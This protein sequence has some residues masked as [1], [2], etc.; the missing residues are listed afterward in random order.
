MSINASK[1]CAAKSA[2]KIDTFFELHN[3]F[4]TLFADFY[5]NTPSRAAKKMRSAGRTKRMDESPRV[6]A[7]ACG[8]SPPN[9]TS[10]RRVTSV[11]VS[12]WSPFMSADPLTPPS[13]SSAS[14]MLV[15]SL[16]ATKPSAL[17][18]PLGWSA[19]PLR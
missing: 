2:A 17:A 14:I 10:I 6:S 15:T 19:E 11:M 9:S 4:T 12:M 13:I 8:Y 16:M 3:T 18:S 7:R 5:P 1:T